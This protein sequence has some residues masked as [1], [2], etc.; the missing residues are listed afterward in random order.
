[1]A[2]SGLI[3]T[4]SERWQPAKARL[5][6]SLVLLQLSD[7]ALI[8]QSFD[9]R[10]PTGITIEAE[11]PPSTCANGLPLEREPLGD[12]IGDLL[13]NEGLI[14]AYVLAALPAAATDW[15]VVVWPFD[16][17]PDEPVESLR[18]INPPLRLSTSLDEASIDLHPLP[19]RPAQMLLG[20]CSSALVDAWVD[21]FNLAG[22]QLERLAPAQSCQMAALTPLLQQAPPGQ[23][24]ALLDPQPGHCRLVLFRS[25]VPVFDHP[26]PAEGSELMQQLHRCLAFYRRWD[27]QAGELRL[28][29]AEP[30]PIQDQ[31]ER[32]LGLQPQL[33]PVAPFRSLV[34]RG[35]ATAEV[36]P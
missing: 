33:V 7:T 20:A 4:I 23:L 8:G 21:V 6:P 25:T 16:E 10:S 19:G 18:Q 12:L 30:M 14:D 13:V 11:I 22:V 5:F 24:T 1:M 28:L 3:D 36:R 9:G 29:L 31:L 15:R 17:I 27:P 32:E 34:L 2:F 26:L 35:L